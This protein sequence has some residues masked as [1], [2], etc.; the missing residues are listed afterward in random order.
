MCFFDIT[1]AK[2]GV[3]DFFAASRQRF[4]DGVG[5]GIKI[6][7]GDRVL[8]EIILVSK[9]A[10]EDACSTG[11]QVG[12]KL[13]KAHAALEPGSIILIMK[14]EN[15]PILHHGEITYLNYTL[16]F[17]KD[18]FMPVACFKKQMG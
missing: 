16:H 4:P 18:E 2:V 5:L 13:L 10:M 6:H 3:K 1:E 11:V 8:V 17:A 12:D 9:E 14:L 15:I 7:R